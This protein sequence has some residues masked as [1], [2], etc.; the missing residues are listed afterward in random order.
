MTNDNTEATNRRMFIQRSAGAGTVAALS[1]LPI[2]QAAGGVGQSEDENWGLTGDKLG[3][4][5]PAER[6]RTAQKKSRT[7]TMAR[8]NVSFSEVV[9]VLEN[10]L[11]A[12]EGLVPRRLLPP[13]DRGSRVRFGHGQD[14]GPP[15]AAPQRRINCIGY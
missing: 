3:M 7:I 4:Q 6:G 8:E 12:G 15:A 1:G 9:G 5:P 13:P 11:V 2:V 14:V 10:T